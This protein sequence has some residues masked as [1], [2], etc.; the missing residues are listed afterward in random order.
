MPLVY[1]TE[2]FVSRILIYIFTHTHTYM[3]VLDSTLSS[4]LTVSPHLILEAVRQWLHEGTNGSKF[5]RVVFSAKAN[6]SLM[7]RHMDDYFPLQPFVFHDR[8]VS[9]LS[10]SNLPQERTENVVS[11]PDKATMGTEN[12]TS[13]SAKQQNGTENEAE[14]SEVV[15]KKSESQDNVHKKALASLHER[16]SVV[17]IDGIGID[18]G[19][20]NVNRIEE[21]IPEDV[22]PESDTVNA[23]NGPVSMENIELELQGVDS[24]MDNIQSIL[25]EMQHEQSEKARQEEERQMEEEEDPLGLLRFLDNKTEAKGMQT[26][27]SLSAHTSPTHFGVNGLESKLSS[28]LPFLDIEVAMNSPPR[29]NA[30]REE[31]DV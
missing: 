4:F 16:D 18:L 19:D 13:E 3:S 21:P 24:E 6:L 25:L 17:S 31:S 12:E 5:E 15:E 22:E 14:E 29:L 30:K 10:E 9:E 7:E 26:S 2:E 23:A 11:E 28:S 27:A 20:E 8:T 1:T